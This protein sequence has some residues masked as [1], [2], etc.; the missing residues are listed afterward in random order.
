MIPQGTKFIGISPNVNLKEKKS[1]VLNS[2]TQPFTI[3]DIRGYKN[4]TVL[5]NQE[6][7]SNSSTVLGDSLI[8]KGVSY[9]IEE[10]PNNEDLMAIGAPS[11]DSGVSFIATD[12][13]DEAYTD[14]VVLTYNTG[15]P[16]AKVFSNTLDATVWFE[17]D[18][19]G[20]YY[21]LFDSY[22]FF[23]PSEYVTITGSFSVPSE[24]LD[25]STIQARPVFFNVLEITSIHN[26]AFENDIIGSEVPCILEIRK[27]E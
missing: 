8:Q 25:V 15:A 7:G 4:L 12:T 1:A 14:S 22:I 5:L 18:S 2:E 23:D 24:G 16:T 11:N 19:D 21:A 20:T 10:N 26:G 6:G 27:Y 3:D 13:V 9:Y 17:F